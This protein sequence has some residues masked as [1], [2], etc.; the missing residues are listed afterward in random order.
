MGKKQIKI[1]RSKS[2]FTPQI[3]EDNAQNAKIL[4]LLTYFCCNRASTIQY[5][6]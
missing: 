1:L 4:S 2:C 5:V 6:D 3:R